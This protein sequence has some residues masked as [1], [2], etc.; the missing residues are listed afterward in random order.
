[1]YLCYGV[2]VVHLLTRR[3]YR[4]NARLLIL[5]RRHKTEATKQ[6]VRV[7]AGRDA[8]RIWTGKDAQI[9][10]CADDT[11]QWFPHENENYTNISHQAQMHHLLLQPQPTHQ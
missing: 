5:I 4:G 10:A 2:D 11:L 9:Q 7:C 6:L 8:G 3:R 1:M